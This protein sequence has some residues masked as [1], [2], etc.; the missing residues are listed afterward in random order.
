LFARFRRVARPP[1]PRPLIFNH[2]ITRLP[3][4]RITR[5]PLAS[6][7]DHAFFHYFIVTVDGANINIVMVKL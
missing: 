5:F 1:R 3:D 6:S 4:H 7:G 2:P